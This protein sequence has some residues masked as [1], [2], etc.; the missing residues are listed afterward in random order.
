M[1]R[2]LALAALVLLLASAAARAEDDPATP[3]ADDR[4]SLRTCLDQRAQDDEPL[5][6]CIGVVSDPCLSEEG[7]DSTP[8]MGACL[9]KEAT[10]WDDSLND[11]YKVLMARLDGDQRQALKDSQR[12]WIAMRD[13]TC[14]FEASLWNG[15]TGA[16]PAAIGCIMRETG[17]RAL[18]L[19]EQMDFLGQ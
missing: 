10:I 1:P 11:W 12:A 13:S 6:N 4:A 16:G 19:H 8:M 3:T 7:N 15:G 5:E 9:D 17:R 14:A 2:P 18:F